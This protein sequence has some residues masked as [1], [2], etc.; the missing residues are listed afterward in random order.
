MFQRHD[1]EMYGIENIHFGVGATPDC[2]ASGG[3]SQLLSCQYRTEKLNLFLFF[4][5]PSSGILR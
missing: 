4:N 3:V 1:T 2:G 5:S